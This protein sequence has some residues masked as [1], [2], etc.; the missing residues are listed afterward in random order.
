MR[1]RKRV[2][3]GPAGQAAIPADTPIRISDLSGT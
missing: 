3:T 1:Y 2:V